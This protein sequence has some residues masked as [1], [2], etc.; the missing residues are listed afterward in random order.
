MTT[1]KA[2]VKLLNGISEV[3]KSYHR[4]ITKSVS[5]WKLCANDKKVKQNENSE[6]SHH[7]RNHNTKEYGK[8]TSGEV[9]LE[10]NSGKMQLSTSFVL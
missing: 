6:N 10:S 8:N 2:S 9:P 4:L 7:H 1:Y 5:H 3:V